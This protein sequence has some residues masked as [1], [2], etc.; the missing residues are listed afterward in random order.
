M[1]QQRLLSLLTSHPI[2]APAAPEQLKELVAAS[3]VVRVSAGE[4]ILREGE[5][6][7]RVFVLA[8]GAVR[9]YHVSPE[10][11]EVLLKLFGAPAVFGEA[12]ALGS[13]ITLE[14]VQAI[15]PCEVLV[16]PV[17]TLLHLLRAEPSCALHLL[18]DVA[19]RFSISIY[20]QRSLAFNP[21]TIRLAN[22]L[23]DYAQWLQQRGCAE[24]HVPL[25]QDQMA[26]SIGVTRRSIAKDISDWQ[27]Q[28][29]IRREGHAYVIDDLPALSRYSDAER[30]ELSYSS[31]QVPMILAEKTTQAGS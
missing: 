20:N 31:E 14:F 29:I 21:A 11:E 5:P 18:V 1:S 9:V 7:D 6:A 30:L 22:L 24:L 10:G 15:E 28:G 26:A 23:V 17:A 2:F 13:Q 27:K 8:E 19:A 12:E 25:T 3:S 16:V 4:V